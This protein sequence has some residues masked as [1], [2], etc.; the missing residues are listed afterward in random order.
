MTESGTAKQWTK[1]LVQ[2][3]AQ[4]AVAVE[5]YTLP[6]YITAMCSIKEKQSEAV[7]IIRS[8]ILEE[9]LHVQL[10]AN[11]C[12]ALDTA[13]NFKPPQYGSDIPYLSPYNPDTGEC[14]FLNASLGPL[15]D[16]TLNTMLDIETPEQA[17]LR[18]D[19]DHTLPKYPY[20]SIGEMYDASYSGSI[21]SVSTNSAGTPTTSKVIGKS[22]IFVKL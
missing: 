1:K 18:Q 15:D 21:K 10:T 8:V 19:L 4:A 7:Q 20:H 6:F 11:L 2:E 16:T 9:L 3:H 17:Q 14:C 12:R 13:P 22:K 5:F